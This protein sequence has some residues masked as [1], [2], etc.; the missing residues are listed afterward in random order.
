MYELKRDELEF[1]LET[2]GKVALEL[3]KKVPAPDGN[4]SLDA[5]EKQIMEAIKYSTIKGI[6]NE[7]GI[8]AALGHIKDMEYAFEQVAA[9][10]QY[11]F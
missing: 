3:A 10:A 2:F 8:F 5:Q 4:S 6:L 7:A 1:R 9:W 11:R